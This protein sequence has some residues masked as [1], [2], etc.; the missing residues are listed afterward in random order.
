MTQQALGTYFVSGGFSK[1]P[2]SLL[3]TTGEISR[4]HVATTSAHSVEDNKR[5]V[6]CIAVDRYRPSPEI[7]DLCKSDVQL[8]YEKRGVR[9]IAAPCTNTNITLGL[10]EK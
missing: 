4:K 3:S 2:V 8:W 9:C 10:K 5:R 7:G 1:L 6:I